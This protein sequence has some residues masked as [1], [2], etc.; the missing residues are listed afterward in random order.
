MIVKFQK[1]PIG[2][3]PLKKGTFDSLTAK[4]G[5][6]I[7]GVMIEEKFCPL[8]VG[9]R[10]NIRNRVYDHHREGGYLNGRKELFDFS[11]G[12]KAV[13]QDIKI[14]NEMWG[15]LKRGGKT[16]VQ[17]EKLF[18][19]LK[20]LLWFNSDLFFQKKLDLLE[21]DIKFKDNKS[22]HKSTITIELP[23][24]LIAYPTNKK[25]KELLDSIVNTKKIISDKFYFAFYE[26]TGNFHD[27]KREVQ[28]ILE[29]IEAL[30]KWSL[31]ENYGLYTYGHT[32][33]VGTTVYNDLCKKKTMSLGM[34][35]D[36]N[37]IHDVLYNAIKHSPSKFN[38]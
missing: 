29:K 2:F 14:W 4:P 33:H 38:F 3:D 30:T 1:P 21:S 27:Y 35:I 22:K 18:N 34:T 31:S 8:Y 20:T 28:P 16:I 12:M 36:F 5:V 7:V 23:E 10:D 6:Y 26:Y 19:K 9:I 17:K 15:S 13:Y 25:I 24:L 32:T 11:N 37:L